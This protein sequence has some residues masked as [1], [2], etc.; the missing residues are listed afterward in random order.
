LPYVLCSEVLRSNK[1]RLD[2]GQ[3]IFL[4]THVKIVDKSGRIFLVREG[5]LSCKL[6]SSRLLIS[7][8]I[9]TT[10]SYKEDSRAVPY[11]KKQI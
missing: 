3:R 11:E 10:S 8:S 9:I 2:H 6:E 5:I 4:S 7:L 1:V